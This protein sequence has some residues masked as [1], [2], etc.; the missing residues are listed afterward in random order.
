[1]TSGRFSLLGL[2]VACACLWCASQASAFVYWTDTGTN[3]I[4]RADLDGTAAS[5]SFIGGAQTPEGIAVDSQYIY[6]ANADGTIGRANL[7]GSDANQS[8]IAGA[9]TPDGIAVNGQ[10]IYWGNESTNTI[11]RANINGTGVD[12]SFITGASTPTGVTVNGQYIYWGNDDYPSNV[13]IARANLD[14]TGVNENFI[15]AAGAVQVAVSAQY[16]YWADFQSQEIFRA[17]LN[18][19]G[20]AGLVATAG[21]PTGVAVDSQYVYWDNGYAGS[22]GTIGRANLDGSDPNQSFITGPDQPAFLAVD[23]GALPI[24][25]TGSANVNVSSATVEGTVNPASE[26]VTDCRFDYGPTTAYGLSAPCA[27]PVGEGNVPVSV[28]ADL[29]NLE[30]G[31]IYHYRLEATSAYGTA[32][33]NDGTF[34]TVGTTMP[35]VGLLTMWD[36]QERTYHQCTATVVYSLSESVILTAGH[37]VYGSG[38]LFTQFLFRPDHTGPFAPNPTSPF[39]PGGSNPFG[40]WGALTSGSSIA[41]F[42]SFDYLVSGNPSYDFAFIVLARNSSGQAIGQVVTGLPIT[43]NPG[44]G[45]GWTAYGYPNGTFNQCTNSSSQD[46]FTFSGPSQMVMNCP[47][48]SGG[49]SGGPWING[50]NRLPG[51]IGAINSQQGS[52]IILPGCHSGLSGTYLSDEALNTFVLADSV[53]L[54][55]A[56]ITAAGGAIDIKATASTFVLADVSNPPISGIRGQVVLATGPHSKLASLASRHRRKQARLLL[57][58]VNKTR[59]RHDESV[60][61]V[62]HLT[63]AGQ[64]WLRHHMCVAAMIELTFSH[65]RTKQTKNNK[66]VLL[67]VRHGHKKQSL[68]SCL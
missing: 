53:A 29:V 37:C 4:A 28:S 39:F 2:L 12:Q 26:N 61:V 64:K 38:H 20:S 63:K 60:R 52:C 16:I 9:H 25:T 17:N 15:R 65:P 5:E 21:V 30:Y 35:A 10:Y 44:R 7:D 48:L 1:M 40:V 56:G 27:Q 43:F 54:K 49:A 6:W 42:P 45:Q 31:Q 55:H 14:G 13:S 41:V 3:T 67:V 62:V 19:T 34:T 57:G 22:G 47:T 33:A 50:S 11:G 66:P 23:A 51:G 59:V 68:A 58:R 46:Q 8:F 18:G 24:V 32:Y 36:T